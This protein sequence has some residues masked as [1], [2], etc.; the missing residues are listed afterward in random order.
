[1]AGKILLVD[2]AVAVLLTLKAV[3]E[4][5]GHTVDTA[6]NTEEAGELL[7]CNRYNL[8]VTDLVFGKKNDGLLI[9]A[10]VRRLQHKTPVVIL[11]AFPNLVIDWRKLGASLLL[12]KPMHTGTL[13]MHLESFIDSDPSPA[14]QPVVEQPPPA[15]ESA[16]FLPLERLTSYARVGLT[17]LAFLAIFILVRVPVVNHFRGFSSS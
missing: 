4:L 17:V 14:E 5:K 15:S 6:K 3:L 16:F 8:V 11:T 12:Q 13:C 7:A 9:V 2:D 10:A 1:M